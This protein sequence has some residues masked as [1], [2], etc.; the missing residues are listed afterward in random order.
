ME[1]Y[2]ETLIITDQRMVMNGTVK[3]T[4]VSLSKGE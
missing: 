3:K 4:E 1:I 2:K